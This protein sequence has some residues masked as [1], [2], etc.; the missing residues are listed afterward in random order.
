MV[1]ADL[2][3]SNVLVRDRAVVAVVDIGNAG[4]GTRATDLT[5]LAVAHLP[6][7]GLDGVRGRLW[8]KRILDLVGWK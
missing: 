3:P 5:T 1:H 6:R 7:S 4:S 2:D 8:D